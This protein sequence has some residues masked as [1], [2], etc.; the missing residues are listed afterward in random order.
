M[1]DQSE[2]AL[3]IEQRLLES[4]ARLRLLAEASAN[5]LYRMSPDWGKM[6]ELDGGGF[7]PGTPS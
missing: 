5:A 4:E 6:K 7:L 1:T 2:D 3:G